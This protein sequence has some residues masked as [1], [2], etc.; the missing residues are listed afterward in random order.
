MATSIREADL[1][2][3]EKVLIGL[4]RAHLTPNSDL[5]RFRWLYQD[6]P[7][8][9]AR[10]WLAYDS[11]LSEPIGMA[12]LFPR[13][14]YVGGE[15]QDGALLG[16]FCVDRNHRTLGTALQL[17]RAQLEIANG[18]RFAICYDFP[19][20]VMAKVYSRIG[21]FVS[22]NSVRLSRPLRIGWNFAD[23]IPLLA[24]LFDWGAAAGRGS[25]ANAAGLH[26]QLEAGPLTSEYD[27]L[28]TRVG[29]AWGDCTARTSEY[30]NWRYL[31][32]PYSKFEIVSARKEKELLAYCVIT[33]SGDRAIIADL[34][35]MPNAI[36]MG[37]LVR[38]VIRR[39]KARGLDAISLPILASRR[40]IRLLGGM[41]FFKREPS[42]V[43]GFGTR[44][45]SA[46]QLF[47]MHGDRES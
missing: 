26:F 19:S 35:G 28:A 45:R 16:D 29:S 9:T 24:S 1:L 18:G 30:L 13:K 5:T 10:A 27:E 23:A 34:F 46:Q 40:C 22:G 43:I 14:M 7:F 31:Q 15:I 11:S 41:G 47:L 4:A 8:G 42:P 32:H 17:L 25:T 20:S 6:N 38:H 21:A 3:D 12:A 33:T 37:K 2:E 44:L 36:V 39:L